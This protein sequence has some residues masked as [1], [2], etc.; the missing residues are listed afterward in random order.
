MRYWDYEV[1]YVHVERKRPSFI[2]FSPF[3][4]THTILSL[5]VTSDF[6]Y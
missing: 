5:V 3:L 1:I 6:S 4:H 2:S